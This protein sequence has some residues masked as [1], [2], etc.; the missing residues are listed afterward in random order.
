MSKTRRI[1][2]EIAKNGY[3]ITV[4]KESRDDAESHE[5]MYQEPEKYVAESEEEAIKIVKDNL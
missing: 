3:T 1:E 2:I 4:Y 5:I